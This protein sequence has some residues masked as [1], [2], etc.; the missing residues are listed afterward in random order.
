[1]TITSTT[2]IGIGRIGRAVAYRFAKAG[3]DVQVLVRDPAKAAVAAPA[4][5]SI[6]SIGEP[7]TGDIVVLA[8]PYPAIDSVLAAYPDGLAGKIVVDPTNP[9]N[10]TTF[11]SVNTGTSSAQELADKLPKA[12]ELKAFN[13]NFHTTLETGTV[14][15]LPVA[16]LVA[17]DD[18]EARAALI[19]LLDASGLRGVDAGPLKRAQRMEALGALQ[20]E[21]SKEGATSEGFALT[22]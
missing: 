2:V 21:L 16:T 15:G 22:R 12:T 1:M 20:I 9:I 11:D 17:G 3:A 5:V 7:I 6:A 4:G 18:A 10:F 19:A 14:G 13:T 8:L